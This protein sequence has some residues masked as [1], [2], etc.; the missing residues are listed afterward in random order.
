[1]ERTETSPFSNSVRIPENQLIAEN[2]YISFNK[3]KIWSYEKNQDKSGLYEVS[4]SGTAITLRDNAWKRLVGKPFVIT[5]QT[6]L[7]FEYETKGDAEIVGLGF[8]TNNRF[9]SGHLLKLS[10]SQNIGKLIPA[11]ETNGEFTKV[12]INLGDYFSPKKYK[13][14]YFILDND[15]NNEAVEVTF[16]NV[17]LS[18]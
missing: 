10:G 3:Y 1:D 16:K 7:E 17:V 5:S 12:S 11:T 9:W 8:D 2:D 18:E 14:M 6:K 13:T 15:A 4:N